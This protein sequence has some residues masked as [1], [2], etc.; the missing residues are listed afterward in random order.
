MKKAI[1][2]FLVAL[3]AGRVESQSVDSISGVGGRSSGW[4]PIQVTTNR[5]LVPALVNGHP[6]TAD[7][8]NSIA[9]RIDQGFVDDNHLASS[10]TIGHSSSV[11][12]TL[13]FGP[14]TVSQPVNAVVYGHQAPTP[15]MDLF[16]GDEVFKEFVVDIDF[17]NQRV[18]FYRPDAFT[19]P[20]GVSPLIFK[21]D[22]ESR[23]VSVSVED[24]L[25]MSFWVYLGDPGAISVHQRYSM[26]HGMLQGRTNS[27]RMG[28]GP[29]T[30]PEAVAT[31]R[32]VKLAGIEFNQ[33]PGVF[34]DDSV[35]G[36]YP[37]D[38]SG[39]IGLGLLSR[40]RVIFDYGRD[41]LYLIP[42]P[43]SAIAAPFP[44]DRSGLVLKK[45]QDDYVV[46]YVC[47]GSPA[48]NAGFQ[49]GDTVVQVNGQP[50]PALPGTAW[51]TAAWGNVQLTDVGRTYVFTLKN[52]AVRKLTTA[53]YF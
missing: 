11:S 43:R 41:R 15:P 40:C 2:L 26:S 16:A 14:V 12:V 35:T 25:P 33:V 18:N 46:R 20:A 42:G 4:I 45:T 21:Q 7:L 44:K 30:P 34:P 13:Q 28:G 22:G 8:I 51:Q 31:V 38:V 39:H 1:G 32:E 17:P 19:P 5:V 50:M 27:I 36:A 47:P 48:A 52:K 24:G 10:A 29:R 9:T 49:V 37:A 23:A 3:I 53:E 6:A